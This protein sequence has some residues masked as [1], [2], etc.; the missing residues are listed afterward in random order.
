M[1]MPP[2]CGLGRRAMGY[3]T[4]AHLDGDVLKGRLR[5]PL[6]KE[7]QRQEDVCR[8]MRVVARPAIGLDPRL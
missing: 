6:K 1:V 5:P 2:C 3:V 4:L 7:G 8:G